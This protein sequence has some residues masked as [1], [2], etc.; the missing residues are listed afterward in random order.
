MTMEA[1]NID[2]DNGENNERIIEP[3]T[4][5]TTIPSWCV[6]VVTTKLTPE[7]SEK[8]LEDFKSTS[9]A[10]QKFSIWLV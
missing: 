7:D 5:W 10:V 9:F 2:D 3:L 4:D 1:S 6:R 8:E